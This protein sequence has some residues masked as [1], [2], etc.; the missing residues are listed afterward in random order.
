MSCLLSTRWK[1]IRNCGSPVC[2]P[3]A[4]ED[5]GVPA[6]R[7]PPFCAIE[8]LRP[9]VIRRL[10]IVVQE[11]VVE[12]R[13]HVARRSSA[14]IRASGRPR[15]RSGRPACRTCSLRPWLVSVS[16]L[17][18][19]SFSYSASRYAVRRALS[20]SVLRRLGSRWLVAAAATA[21]QERE[22]EEVRMYGF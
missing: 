5:V 11:V 12:H 20:L 18:A 15:P 16:G 3:A 9:D 4:R 2:V 17:I 1:L 10:G 14:A 21:Q 7:L 13:L 19:S 6:E 22:D 8:L